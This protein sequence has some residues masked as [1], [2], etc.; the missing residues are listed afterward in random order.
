M[1]SQ[2]RISELVF[3]WNCKYSRF[4]TDFL[5]CLFWVQKSR[6]LGPLYG[7]Q[8]VSCLIINFRF[9]IIASILAVMSGF[10]PGKS[11][12][13]L[14]SSIL[15]LVSLLSSAVYC[16]FAILTLVRNDIGLFWKV[17]F[18]SCVIFSGMILIFGQFLTDCSIKNPNIGLYPRNLE[19]C[20]K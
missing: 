19:N 4:G 9:P 12:M 20:R 2:N 15:S 5:N 6:F 11:Q 1:I 3:F 16:G 7:L 18:G 13:H 8:A 10:M 14:I 17:L